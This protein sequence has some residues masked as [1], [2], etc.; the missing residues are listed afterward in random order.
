MNAAPC[1]VNYA[2]MCGLTDY[3]NNNPFADS[4]LLGGG[5]PRKVGQKRIDLAD[6]LFLPSFVLIPFSV[7]QTGLSV[8]RTMF[9]RPA[10]RIRRRPTC[11]GTG[12]GPS[13][14]LSV[15]P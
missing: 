9:P 12:I 11:Q 10:N 13:A 1:R 7:T 6:A 14:S 5:T 4:G 2:I 3:A 15:R 8:N